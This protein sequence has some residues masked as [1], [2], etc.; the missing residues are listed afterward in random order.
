MRAYYQGGSGEPNR[1]NGVSNNYI[2]G[3]C[4]GRYIKVYI[5]HSKCVRTYYYWK[6]ESDNKNQ[7]QTGKNSDKDR[8]YTIHQVFPMEN[9]K[10]VL[11][12]DL[13]K[14]LYG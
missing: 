11:Y 9:L 8:S 4:K 5:L 3:L 10:A 2:S 13:I 1:I 14:Y 12:V 6:R 7:R